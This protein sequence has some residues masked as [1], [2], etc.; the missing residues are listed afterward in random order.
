MCLWPFIF[1]RKGMVFTQRMERHE[2]IHAEQ[3]KE[4]LVV[5]FLVWYAV[6]WLVKLF[7]YGDGHEAYRNVSFEREAYEWQDRESYISCRKRYAWVRY[8]I[9][10][11]GRHE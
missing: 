11:G 3:Q 4:M 7:V 5:L 1:V 9:K 10:K 8:I 2:C 6:E